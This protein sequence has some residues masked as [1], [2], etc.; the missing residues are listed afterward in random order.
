L[1]QDPY[2]TFRPVQA[3]SRLPGM[4]RGLQAA[5]AASAF[6]VPLSAFSVFFKRDRP[7][8]CLNWAV[9]YKK[10]GA[11]CGQGHELSF[12]ITTGTTPWLAKIMHG[13]DVCHNFFHRI[14]DNSCMNVVMAND[15]DKWYSG[16]WCYVSKECPQAQPTNGSSL[17]AAKLCTPGV[18]P[19][20]RDRSPEELHRWA[21]GNNLDMGLVVRMAYPV[22]SEAKWP[23]VKAYFGQESDVASKAVNASVLAKLKAL[24]ESGRPIVL[25]SHNRHLPYAVVT[26]SKA[27]LLE[28]DAVNMVSGQPFTF[29]SWKCVKGCIR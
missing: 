9:V 10:K 18:D 15:P 13:E 1:C 7:C 4:R 24:Q 23:L 6:A 14:N 25:D 29:T 20:L 19:M 2:R 22:E 5:L 11:I 21:N 26:G 12:Q 8:E 27:F 3:R 16:Q 28:K 17:V